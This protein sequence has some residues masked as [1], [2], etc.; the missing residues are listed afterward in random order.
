[1]LSQLNQLSLNA[2]GRYATD[3]ELRFLLPYIHSFGLRLQTYQQIQA[4]EATIVQEV[5]AKLREIDPSLLQRGN[6]DLS[7]KWKRDTLRVL[8]YSAVAMLLDDPHSLQ[9]KLLL[10]FQTVM[11]AF[12]A[13][14]SCNLTY[15]VMQ[16]VVKE[17][18]STQQAQVFCPILEVNR[19]LLGLAE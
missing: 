12:G 9:E 13:Q 11:K 4:S 16:A 5:Y 10:W 18:L 6:E 7:V 1:M 3:E 19:Q 17:H 8:R 15:S 14:R 2:D